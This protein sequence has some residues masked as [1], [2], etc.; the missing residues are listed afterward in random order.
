MLLARPLG[1]LAHAALSQRVEGEIDGAFQIIGQGFEPVAD[2]RIAEMLFSAELAA[3]GRLHQEKD[4]A[5][6]EKKNFKQCFVRK[7]F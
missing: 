5:E 2:V 4:A 6:D 3:F 7:I 1:W